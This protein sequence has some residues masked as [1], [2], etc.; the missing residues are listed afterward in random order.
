VSS[1]SPTP[2]QTRSAASHLSIGLD[3][4]ALA[5]VIAQNV[6][7][8]IALDAPRPIPA[9]PSVSSPATWEDEDPLPQIPEMNLVGLQET[10][11]VPAS[12]NAILCSGPVDAVGREDQELART[13]GLSPVGGGPATF[14]LWLATGAIAG[15]GVSWTMGGT[16]MTGIAAGAALGAV[17]GWG[18]LRWTSPK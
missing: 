2:G 3:H 14:V 1:G 11:A 17:T 6:S 15:T 16:T 12:E 5:T 9:L 8:S 13:D 10:D 7:Q 4:P 18:W